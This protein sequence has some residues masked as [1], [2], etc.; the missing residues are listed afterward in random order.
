MCFASFC[1]QWHFH[2]L[3]WQYWNFCGK[4]FLFLDSFSCTSH[5]ALRSL[6]SLNNSRL[7]ADF[8]FNAIFWD[9]L[10]IT[11]LTLFGNSQLLIDDFFL[12]LCLLL[13]KCSLWMLLCVW[14]MPVVTPQVSLWLCRNVSMR[15]SVVGGGVC[16][17]SRLTMQSCNLPVAG[18]LVL[19]WMICEFKWYWDELLVYQPMDYAWTTAVC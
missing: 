10:I 2:N 9:P 12:L 18:C 19:M 16:T 15:G 14:R 11:L 6:R 17:S 5:L 4:N 8:V 7:A 13:C 3:L 1:V